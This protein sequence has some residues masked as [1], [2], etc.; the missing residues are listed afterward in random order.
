MKK[1][2]FIVLTVLVT[3]FLVVSCGGNGPKDLAKQ[4]YQL[5]QDI[6]K[7]GNNVAKAASLA[8]K[9]AQV[10]EKVQ[11]LSQA[12]ALV[13]LQELTRLK[14]GGSSSSSNQTKTSNT[15]MASNSGIQT[16]AETA[17]ARGLTLWEKDIT[18]TDMTRLVGYIQRGRTNF[19]IT[20]EWTKEQENNLKQALKRVENRKQLFRLD[21]S[22]LTTPPSMYVYD[23][24]VGSITLPPNLHGAY[25]HSSDLL[26]IN[27]VESDIGIQIE[28]IFPKIILPSNFKWSYRSLDGDERNVSSSIR[29]GENYVAVLSEGNSSVNLGA[30]EVESNKKIILIF[31]ST[32]VELFGKIRAEIDTIYC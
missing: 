4:T 17:Q 13:Y 32:L 7:A 19:K 9:A 25:I 14:S 2:F 20:G 22:G 5:E 23:D 26:E 3:G 31:L 12:E 28:G 6:L 18:E 10:A 27:F 16:I 29:S 30:F 1:A 8:V 15:N 21:F 24:R 11:K